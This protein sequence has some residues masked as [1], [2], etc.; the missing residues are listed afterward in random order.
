MSLFDQLHFIYN[1]ISFFKNKSDFAFKLAGKE[2][3]CTS[4][5]NLIE[6]I[7]SLNTTELFEKEIIQEILGVNLFTLP[8][9]SYL[10][11]KFIATIYQ[12]NADNYKLQKPEFKY[13]GKEIINDLVA[14]YICKLFCGKDYSESFKIAFLNWIESISSI[15]L[16]SRTFRK[17]WNPWWNKLKYYEHVLREKIEILGYSDHT[18]FV[19]LYGLST[20]YIID[21]ALLFLF[22]SY[23]NI[24][25]SLS[26]SI[27]EKE[28]LPIPFL[29][30]TINEDFEFEGKQ[31]VTGTHIGI[32]PSIMKQ[33]P[34]GFN[35]RKCPGEKL[36]EK[37]ID[38][39][40]IKFEEWYEV[41]KNVKIKY[42]RFRFSWGPKKF[43]LKEKKINMQEYDSITSA[44]GYHIIIGN[45]AGTDFASMTIVM[46]EE[47]RENTGLRFIL[48]D[49]TKEQLLKLKSQVEKTLKQKFNI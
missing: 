39:V 28:N 46:N 47:D 11:N 24:V 21:Q 4:N 19:N 12:L 14:Q 27:L 8:F 43:G 9:N 33:K 15:L 5:K 10:K 3:Y 1:P 25:I 37:I 20:E 31:L 22:A 36:T 41:D 48:I 35:K 13:N 18:N 40:L 30:K 38:D 45:N 23:D 34:F 44:N 17:S 42:G 32:L 6:K 7:S 16:F 29:P 26:N 2:I 49:L